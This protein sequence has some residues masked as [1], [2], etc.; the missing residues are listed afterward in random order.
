M[1]KLLIILG[2]VFASGA[3]APWAFADSTFSASPSTWLLS[4]D[5]FT[6]TVGGTPNGSD[7]GDC[8]NA[9]TG[10]FMARVG[11]GVVSPQSAAGDY[12]DTLANV[13]SGTFGTQDV[14]FIGMNVDS[15]TGFSDWSAACDTSATATI[16]GCNALAGRSGYWTFTIAHG[17]PPPPPPPPAATSTVDQAEQNLGISFFLFLLSMCAMIW[18]IRKN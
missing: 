3:S 1:K 15:G 8:F 6:W 12:T 14:T 2:I 13:C 9:G 11:S 16:T 7:Y 18:I 4:T 10:A 17:S 5:S